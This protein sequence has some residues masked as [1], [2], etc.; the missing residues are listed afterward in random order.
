MILLSIFSFDKLFVYVN[1]KYRTKNEELKITKEVN[2]SINR[3]VVICNF[4]NFK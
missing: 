3:L 4:I 2:A 1:E